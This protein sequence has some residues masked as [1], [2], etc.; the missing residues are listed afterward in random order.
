MA[1]EELRFT[2]WWYL[3]FVG[4]DAGTFIGGCF[5]EADDVGSALTLSHLLGCN[6]GGEVMGAPV[7]EG[8]LPD[9]SFRNRLL[10][11]AEIAS[12]WPDAKRVADMEDLEIDGRCVAADSARDA[13]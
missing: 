1:S 9:D 12:F 8:F 4:G 5:V 3:S 7:P 6:P 11:K 13:S 10:T 2:G